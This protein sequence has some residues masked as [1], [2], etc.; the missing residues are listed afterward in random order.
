MRT[1]PV[2]DFKATDLELLE[3]LTE[4]VTLLLSEQPD[5]KA[6]RHLFGKLKFREMRRALKE[7]HNVSN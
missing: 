7:D 1:I 3:L 2:F 6:K 5:P 4:A